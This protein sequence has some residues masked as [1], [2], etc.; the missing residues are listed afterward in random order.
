MFLIRYK[1]SKFFLVKNKKNY[2]QRNFHLEFFHFMGRGKPQEQEGQ[3]NTPER[4]RVRDYTARSLYILEEDIRN[5]LGNLE[6]KLSGITV[7]VRLVD[8]K[9]SSILSKFRKLEDRVASVEKGYE[10]IKKDFAVGISRLSGIFDQKRGEIKDDNNKLREDLQK[11]IENI[12]EVING[13]KRSTEDKLKEHEFTLREQSINIEKIGNKE[14]TQNQQVGKA[15]PS[16]KKENSKFYLEMIADHSKSDEEIIQWMESNKDTF[17]VFTSDAK[18]TTAIMLC[19]THLRVE[20]FK[21]IVEREGCKSS[22][23]NYKNSDRKNAGSLL[24]SLIQEAE[25]NQDSQK[26][27]KLGKMKE[28][29]TAAMKRVQD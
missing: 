22:Y 5:G 4:E 1:I 14:E 7:E 16:K 28:S 27:E 17:S 15:I 18:N 10:E 25:K 21:N 19:A 23:L 6:R 8:Q 3:R 11:E 20:L 9:L 26:I 2:A 29:F 12:K 24:D 13:F